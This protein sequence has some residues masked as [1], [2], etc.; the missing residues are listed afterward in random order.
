MRAVDGRVVHVQQAR[1]PQLGQ[2]YLVQL[3]PDSGLGPV[4]QT[5]P[6]RHTTAANLFSRNVPPAHALAQHVND[7]PQRSTV[8]RRQPP[9]IPLPPRRTSRQQRSHTFPQVI[10]HKIS[11]HPTDPADANPTAKRH[12][13][14]HSETIS[15]Q[16]SPSIAGS[17]LLLCRG[18]SWRR[19]VVFGQP[20]RSR[21][22][23]R[24]RR[25]RG[26]WGCV[27]RVCG[28]GGGW[29]SD[30]VAGV[31]LPVWPL[32]C[33]LEVVVCVPPTQSGL[34]VPTVSSAASHAYEQICIM[35]CPRALTDR[36]R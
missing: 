16:P 2:Q 35:L 9:G 27:P 31:K 11:R 3:R 33:R 34:D 15:Y 4:P 29:G 1:G 17:S 8:I 10:R 18:L 6:G 25:S 21:A 12:N 32:T 22:A 20:S 7:A 30:A 23:S 36:S 19:R 5:P 26:R 13:E 14:L 28:V 24:M